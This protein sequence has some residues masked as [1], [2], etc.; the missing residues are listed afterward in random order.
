M[1]LFDRLEMLVSQENEK[2]RSCRTSVNSEKFV[3][4][5]YV[6]ARMMFGKNFVEKVKRT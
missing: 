1:I 6:H 5:M 4:H 2:P 3:M